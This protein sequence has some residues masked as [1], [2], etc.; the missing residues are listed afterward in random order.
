MVLAPGALFGYEPGLRDFMRFNVA[1]CD[2]GRVQAQFEGLLGAP[3]RRVGA[4][5][6]DQAEG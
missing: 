5:V 4:G 3:T 2:E 6:T 1:H